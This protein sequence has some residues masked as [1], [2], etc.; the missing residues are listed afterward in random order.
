MDTLLR[1]LRLG[2]FFDID[3]LDVLTFLSSLVHLCTSL[4]EKLEEVAVLPRFGTFAEG[5]RK[6][7]PT[8]RAVSGL[9]SGDG[10]SL[11]REALL[12]AYNGACG[13]DA[14]AAQTSWC[15]LI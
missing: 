3:D 4:S 5:K 2:N 14:V 13:G 11:L 6:E 15:F 7:L 12:F 10:E 1:F 9:R 8:G